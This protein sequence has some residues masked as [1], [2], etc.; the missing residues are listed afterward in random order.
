MTNM[1]VTAFSL[2]ASASL[3]PAHISVYDEE[4]I[5]LST[6]SGQLLSLNWKLRSGRAIAQNIGFGPVVQAVK[7]GGIVAAGSSIWTLPTSQK[8]SK[9][10]DI[11]GRP[12]AI[13]FSGTLFA[14]V[15]AEGIRAYRF[16]KNRASQLALLEDGYCATQS[17]CGLTIGVVRGSSPRRRYMMVDVRRDGT[18]TKTELPGLAGNSNLLTAASGP[19]KIAVVHMEQ[20]GYNYLSL[21]NAGK[22]I[23][24][25][26]TSSFEHAFGIKYK[27]GYAVVALSGTGTVTF[28]R[29]DL[30]AIKQL[31]RY[32]YATGRGG[33]DFCGAFI[34]VERY[35]LITSNQAIELDTKRGKRL[36]SADLK[37]LW[38]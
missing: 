18:L 21:F 32:T 34:D 33:G 11:K 2:L 3:V 6:F 37:E 23:A 8:L 28:Y 38:N 19:G 20:G 17:E 16:F 4:H 26:R 35:L 36:A 13:D 24:R 7:G 25:C 5:Y 12:L 30:R 15:S 10:T 14:T 1:G 31:G 27:R 9:P 29:I 22:L